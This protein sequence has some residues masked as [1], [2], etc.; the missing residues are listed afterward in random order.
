MLSQAE[1]Q[2]RQSMRRPGA[3][4]RKAGIARLIA[5]PIAA[6][7]I[8]AV[9]IAPV[10]PAAASNPAASVPSRIARNVPIS[11]N[12]LPPTSSASSSTSGSRPYFAGAKKVECTP[13]R[14]SALSSTSMLCTAN[15]SAAIV[16]MTIS[17]ALTTLSTTALSKRSAS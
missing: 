7:P 15:P 13:I 3:A 1:V 12:A 5:K 14:N 8:K 17:A 9:A 4:G 16:M 11:T 6:T 2:G 10:L